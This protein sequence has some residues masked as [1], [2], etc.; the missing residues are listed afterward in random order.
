MTL[1][2][3]HDA[4]L[5]N[6]NLVRCFVTWG[7]YYTGLNNGGYSSSCRSAL[8]MTMQDGEEPF[9]E[10][11]LQAAPVTPDVEFLSMSGGKNML[12]FGENFIRNKL[13]NAFLQ[14][15]LGPGTNDGLV[16]E[17]SSD[18]SNKKFRSCSPTCG[19]HI[20]SGSYARYDKTNHSFLIDTQPLALAAISFAKA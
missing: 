7:E 11:L 6:G 19:K 15:K 20:G 2:T 16:A 9:L 17:S 3:P 5:I 12:K 4:T 1:G 8:Q 10:K 14:W 13:L 18:F